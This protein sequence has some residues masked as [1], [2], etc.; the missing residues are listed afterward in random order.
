MT[1]YQKQH[2]FITNMSNCFDGTEYLRVFCWVSVSSCVLTGTCSQIRS[3][4]GSV[5]V[6]LVV[7]SGIRPTGRR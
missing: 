3:A 1:S 6:F 7:I 5:E 4:V 2:V